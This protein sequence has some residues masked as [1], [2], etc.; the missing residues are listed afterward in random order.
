MPSSSI[1][2]RNI[3]WS[4][5][6]STR[7]HATFHSFFLFFF[8]E[9]SKRKEK[10][11]LYLCL[12]QFPISHRHSIHLLFFLYSFYFPKKK[13]HSFPYYIMVV[14]CSVQ[15]GFGSSVST[16]LNTEKTFFFFLAGLALK[17]R[18]N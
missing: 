3:L 2:L 5:V 10:W 4:D 8:S 6:Q 13:V 15:L 17:L 12:F 9:E 16:S 1:G 7:G 14:A 11:K 18:K